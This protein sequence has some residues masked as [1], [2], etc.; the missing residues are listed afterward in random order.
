MKAK[1]RKRTKPQTLRS[2]L[3]ASNY[4]LITAL[5]SSV[6]V[7]PERVAAV[8]LPKLRFMEKAYAKQK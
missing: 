2:K 6:L 4:S 8:T 3:L 7:T 1:R 5:W